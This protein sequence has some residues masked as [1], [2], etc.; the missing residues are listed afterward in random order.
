VSDAAADFAGLRRALIL[1]AEQ[2]GFELYV[3]GSAS[4]PWASAMFVG[5]RH[6]AVIAANASPAFDAWLAKMPD[7]DLP[8]RG[9][10]IASL[11]LGERAPDGHGNDVVSIEALTIADA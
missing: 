7:A 8:L 1:S 9:Q 4:K 6:T 11:E 10:F 5:S 2:A 3:A